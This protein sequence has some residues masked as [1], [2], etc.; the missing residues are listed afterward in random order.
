MDAQELP[1]FMTIKEVAGEN[2]VIPT[3]W[4]E[5]YLYIVYRLANIVE[6]C[7]N[8][9]VNFDYLRPPGM[10][11]GSV[12]FVWKKII[13]A[14]G[15]DFNL[16]DL[17]FYKDLYKQYDLEHFTKFETLIASTP[18]K[19]VRSLL[20]KISKNKFKFSDL[21]K[22]PLVHTSLFEWINFNRELSLENR[23]Q[24]RKYLYGYIQ[25]YINGQLEA[26]HS[27]I[28]LFN[29]QKD[30]L[31]EVLREK[32]KAYGNEF[33]VSAAE[34]FLVED[35]GWLFLHNLLAFEYLGLLTIKKL[36]ILDYEK[37]LAG[38][39]ESY[40]AKIEVF[41]KALEDFGGKVQGSSESAVPSKM[42]LK[43]DTQSHILSIGDKPVNFSNSQKQRDLLRI[44]F[45]DRTKKWNSDELWSEFDPEVDPDQLEKP[46]QVFYSA[47][48]EINKKV[49]EKAAISNFIDHTT[50]EFS[51]NSELI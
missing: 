31:V 51:I 24:L 2:V 16:K 18:N 45:L 50:K 14:T 5:H 12:W 11:V 4:P 39:G 26:E 19:A 9:E 47:A 35:F 10:E 43:Y 41:D 42:E 46:W 49:K 21:V 15:I 40:T 23:S 36:Y 44:L 3:Y 20:L 32:R 8:E 22:L 38:Q 37:D 30:L 1:P 33:V 48:L 28:L 6:L 17:V 29:K 7:P 13:A 34:F 25:N 27:N